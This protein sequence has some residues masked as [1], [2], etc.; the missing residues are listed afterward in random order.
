MGNL[1]DINKFFEISSNDDL[2]N[3]IFKALKNIVEFDYGCLYYTEP[4]KMIAEFGKNRNCAKCISNDLKYKSTKF[5]EIVLYRDKNFDK[6]E[7]ELFKTSAYIISNIIKD[8]EISKIMKLQIEALQNGYEELKKAEKIKSNFISHISHELRTPLNSIIGISDLL[9]NGITGELNLKQKE[10]VNDIKASGLTLLS[11]INEILDISKIE[12]NSVSVNVSTFSIGNLFFE[13][14]NIVKPLCIQKNILLVKNIQ[15]FMMDADYLKIRQILL[16][17]L[18]N[19]VKFTPNGGKVSI[20]VSKD[21]QN[22]VFVV[23]DNGIGIEAKFHDKIFEKFVQVNPKMSNS[24]GLGL[25]VVKDFVRLH[26]GDVEVV[27]ELNKGAKFI[28]KIPLCF[29]DNML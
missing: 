12:S 11:I 22:A 7:V 20:T 17:L 23:E 15:D 13:I 27:S 29:S 24:T 19:A 6:N 25:S 14:D 5:G 16:N 18:S 8:S 10:Y 3:G 21:S 26:N 4:K 1:S 2:Y 9:E 28:V